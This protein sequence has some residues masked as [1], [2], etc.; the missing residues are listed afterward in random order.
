A[1]APSGNLYACER[2]VAEDD[3]PSRVIGHV[4]RGVD[5]ARVRATRWKMPR[6]HATNA[7]CD[8]CAERSRCS[9]ACAGANLAGTGDMGTAGGVQCWYEQTTMKL[10]DALADTLLAESNEA[11]LRR[12]FPRGRDRA[13]PIHA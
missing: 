4:S 11:F 6:H 7:E 13:L 5:A 9:A 10:A 2:L 1:V 8:G 3:D 12:F